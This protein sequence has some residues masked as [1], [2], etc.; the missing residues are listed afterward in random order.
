MKARRA[1]GLAW[2][3]PW[4]VGGLVAQPWPGWS[5]G[6]DP[7][8]RKGGEV[9][10]RAFAP[11]A[12]SSHGSVVRFDRGGTR[13][14]LGA[15]ITAT[16]LVL[17]KAS[18]IQG[19]EF[20]CRLPDGSE[21]PARLV[22]VDDRSDLALVKVEAPGLRPVVWAT[23]EPEVG[24]WTVT[25]GLEP[26][27]EA[28]GI[29]STSPRRI[30]HRRAL[31][32]IELDL[33]R[34]EPRVAGLL[35][36]LGAERAGLLVGD[37]VLEVND[38]AVE[39]REE[40]VGVLREFREGQQVRLRVRRAEELIEVD[41]GMGVPM[42]DPGERQRGGDRSERMNRMGG[43]PSARADGFQRVIT[44]DTVLQA[45]QCGGPLLNLDGQA[46]GLNIARAGRVASYALPARLAQE[47]AAELTAGER[48]DPGQ[49]DGASDPGAVQ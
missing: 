21:V 38:A 40:L 39:S 32:G 16:G 49:G 24:Q 23:A 8:H 22:R 10:L 15:V 11:V 2:L 3:L 45:W 20:T 43:E 26:V 25:P 41:V 12:T 42:P 17:T 14:A 37:I 46:I 18:E 13:L 27:P 35:P 33:N 30:L 44:H 7:A 5:P 28:V 36:G 4:A 34:R 1:I 31:I 47:I 19:D 9:T 6:L 29:V 48:T